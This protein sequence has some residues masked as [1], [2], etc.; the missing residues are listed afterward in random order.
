MK[1]VARNH[2]FVAQGYRAGFTDDGTHDGTHDGRLTVFDLVSRKT[3][4]TR[5]RNVAAQRDFNRVDLE[6][7]TP[8]DLERSLGDFEG[9]AISAIRCV[10]ER[11]GHLTDDE[12]NHVVTLMT[13]LVV[14]NPRLRRAVNTARRHEV[15]IIGDI[16]TSDRRI[17]EHHVA[18]AKRDGFVPKHMDV[19]FEEIA[20]FVKADQYTVEA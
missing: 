20:E 9:K 19:P 13:L 4:R 16:L 11:G 1:N 10:Q 7:R 18:K 8:D 15:R 12:L 17:Y 14:R 5:P 3:F 6:G 2:H